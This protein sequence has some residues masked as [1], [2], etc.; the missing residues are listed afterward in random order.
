MNQIDTLPYRTFN[1][2]KRTHV[3]KTLVL[4]EK[5]MAFQ[6]LHLA[7]K[8]HREYIK[9]KFRAMG[10]DVYRFSHN[11]TS[12]DTGHPELGLLFLANDSVINPALE[13]HALIG[14]NAKYL[15]DSNASN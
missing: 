2:L 8:D 1:K 10:V 7:F 6:G 3:V 4:G 13:V 9:H 11:Y 5:E 15:G 12:L 14:H